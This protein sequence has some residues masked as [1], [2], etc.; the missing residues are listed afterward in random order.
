MNVSESP[1]NPGAKSRVPNLIVS[2]ESRKGGVG[3]TTAALCLSQLLRSRNYAVLFLDLDI[4]GTNAADIAKS[5]FWESQVSIVKC[6][7]DD[8]SP[9]KPCNLLQIFDQCYMM[10]KQIPRFKLQ[11]DS[12]RN[13]IQIYSDKIN[14]IGSQIYNTEIDRSKDNLMDDDLCIMKPSVLFDEL[15]SYWLLDFVKQLI[16][17]FVDSSSK[18]A[19]KVAIVIDNSPGFVGIAPTIHEWLTDLGPKRGKFLFVSSL[20]LQDLHSCNYAINY[21]HKLF[22]SKWNTHRQYIEADTTSNKMSTLNNESF[23]FRLATSNPGANTSSL[24]FFLNARKGHQIDDS[25]IGKLFISNPDKY[26]AIVLNRVPRE[27]K[28][29]SFDGVLASIDEM[30]FSSIESLFQSKGIRS[31]M[32]FYDE[33]IENQFLLTLLRPTRGS[34]KLQNKWHRLIERVDMLEEKISDNQRIN[35]RG[36]HFFSTDHVPDIEWFSTRLAQLNSIITQTLTDL[37]EMGLFRKTRLIHDEWLPGSI[38]PSFRLSLSSLLRDCKLPFIDL[39]PSEY[40]INLSRNDTIAYTEMIYGGLINRVPQLIKNPLPIELDQ[41]LK[42]LT[43]GISILAGLSF[44]PLYWDSPIDMELLNLFAIVLSIE[45]A[46][47]SKESEGSKKK[48]TL[49]E[50]LAQESV[51]L[52]ELRTGRDLFN[53]SVRFIKHFLNKGDEAF[54]EFYRSC[55]AAQARLL[56]LEA[57]S[58]FILQV[59]RY[60]VNHEIELNSKERHGLFPYIR[61]IAQKVILEKTLAHSEAQNELVKIHQTKEYFSEFNKVLDSILSNWEIEK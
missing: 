20:D 47:W 3:K 27:V 24:A 15:H 38:V 45:V 32:V 43:S 51:S 14:I 56:D 22:T 19:L 29:K 25:D 7:R 4:T 21:V 58:R 42:I 34:I 55:T 57:D 6:G 8:D 49:Q 35:G 36:F 23:F 18:K 31:R 28:W 30:N 52:K 17:D 48:R 53:G 26:L 39:S 33:Y 59:I 9:S 54:V 10:G 60:L 44:N 50:F 41:L 2:V 5:P 46:H 1:Q 37:D 11:S 13:S 40:D 16:E 61:G 12:S